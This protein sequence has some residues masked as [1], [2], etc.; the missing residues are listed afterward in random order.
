MKMPFKLSFL[1]FT[2]F[3]LVAAVKLDLF[4]STIFMGRQKKARYLV[5]TFFQQTRTTAENR[6]RINITDPRLVF[7]NAPGNR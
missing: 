7:L 5:R 3:L 4:V 1:S 2:Y 6:H